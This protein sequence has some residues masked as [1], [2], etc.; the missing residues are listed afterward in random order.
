MN[1]NKIHQFDNG[2]KVFNHQLL[3]IQK[4]R[5]EKRN[6]HEEDEEDLFIDIIK[7]LKKD[8]V[9]VSIG[10]A[11]GYYPLL[12]KKLMDEIQIHCFEPLPIHLHYLQENIELNGYTKDDFSIHELAVSISY[13]EVPFANESYGSA[14]VNNSVKPPRK[15]LLK[16]IVKKLLGRPTYMPTIKVKSIPMKDLFDLT[17]SNSIDFVQMDIQGHEHSVLEKYFSDIDLSQQTI[18]AF[19]IGTHGIAIHNACKEL[20]EANNYKMVVDEF[21]TKNQPDGIIYCV[22]L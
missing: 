13:D 18:K 17:K 15:T 4:V 20:L 10:T 12:A 8:A 1:V 21:E 5:Y 3:P 6:V 2:V 19:L 14:V 9:Y 16:N 11:I 7:G 22:I